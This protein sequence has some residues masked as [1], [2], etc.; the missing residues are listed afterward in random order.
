MAEIIRSVWRRIFGSRRDDPT[1]LRRPSARNSN[2]EARQPAP[3]TTPELEDRIR[4]RAYFLWRDDGCPAGR[5]MHYWARAEALVRQ[6]LRYPAAT[7]AKGDD[8]SCF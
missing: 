7:P 4:E 2:S 8:P 6:E 3:K 5:D 1:L